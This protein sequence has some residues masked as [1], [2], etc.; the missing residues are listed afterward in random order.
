[1]NDGTITLIFKGAQ[2]LL[3]HGPGMLDAALK[4]K[5]LWESDPGDFKVTIKAIQA[6]GDAADAELLKATA[7]WRLEKGIVG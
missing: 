1:M 2:L 7:A 4:I 3:T 6:T 5:K